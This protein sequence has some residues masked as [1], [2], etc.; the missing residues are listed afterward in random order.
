MQIESLVPGERRDELTARGTI[1]ALSSTQ[2]HLATARRC[3]RPGGVHSASEPRTTARDPAAPPVF[4]APRSAAVMNLKT[5]VACFTRRRDDVRMR[6]G[7]REALL[8]W[9]LELTLGTNL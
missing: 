7:D 8:F 2:R 5:A 6:Q 1:S 3:E 9:F 4:E